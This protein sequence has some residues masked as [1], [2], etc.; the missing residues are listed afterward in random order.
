MGFELS[1]SFQQE[2]TFINICVE[3][4][5]YVF[6]IKLLS[7]LSFYWRI[8]ILPTSLHFLHIFSLGFPAPGTKASGTFSAPVADAVT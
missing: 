7:T 2:I 6:K 1:N 3:L 5:K 4:F 8:Y